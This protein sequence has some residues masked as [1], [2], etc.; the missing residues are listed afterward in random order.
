MPKKTKALTLNSFSPYLFL[1]LSLEFVSL[2]AGII[3]D[4]GNQTFTNTIYCISFFLI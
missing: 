4:F 3:F 1:T 2:L